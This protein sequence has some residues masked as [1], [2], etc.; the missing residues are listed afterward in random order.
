MATANVSEDGKQTTFTTFQQLHCSP[1]LTA[2]IHGQLHIYLNFKRFSVHYYISRKYSDPSR[3][4][5][6]AFASSAVQTLAK[7]PCNIWYLCRSYCRA[8][9]CYF[10]GDCSQWTL[11]YLSLRIRGGLCNRLYFV[12]SVSVDTEASSD[13]H[14]LTNTLL[15]IELAFVE[16]Y[17]FLG[18][19]KRNK[20]RN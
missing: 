15:L 17:H 7:E 14:N 3:S 9:G 8:S 20:V 12:C 2:G 13:G 16:L 18:Y 11:R 19:R 5:Q 4:S 6:W 10:I 1:D